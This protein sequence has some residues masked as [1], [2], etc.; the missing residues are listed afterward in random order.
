M[1]W[2]PVVFPYKSK[3]QTGYGMG[4]VVRGEAAGTVGGRAQPFLA[5]HSGAA[6]GAS[7]ALVIMP[8]TDGPPVAPRT[9]IDSSTDGLRSVVNTSEESLSR[10]DDSMSKMRVTRSQGVVVAV[11]FNLQEV[12]C[13]TSVCIQIAEEFL[14]SSDLES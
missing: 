9:V 5:A 2:T 7:S 3:P 12:T 13:V 6:V 1:M 14:L 10:C 4:W 8:A 11:L